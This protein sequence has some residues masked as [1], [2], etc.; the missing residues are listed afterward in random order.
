[1]DNYASKDKE[2]LQQLNV[3]Y[4]DR[5]SGSTNPNHTECL[6]PR[7]VKAHGVQTDDDKKTEQIHRQSSYTPHMQEKLQR[8]LKFFFMN[9]V[10]KWRA[11]GRFPWKLGIQALKLCVVTMQVRFPFFFKILFIPS[12]I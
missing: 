11:K 6:T 7:Y 4:I 10:E 1:M 8:K 3:D 5:R 12:P 2:A 9:P